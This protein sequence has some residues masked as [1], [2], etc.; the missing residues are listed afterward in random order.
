M[1]KVKTKVKAGAYLSVTL[2]AGKGG[3]PNNGS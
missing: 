3:G 2:A 1:M